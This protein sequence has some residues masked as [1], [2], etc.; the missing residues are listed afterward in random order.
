MTL[1]RILTLLN[2][3]MFL[4][5]GVWGFY[6]PD[7][8][9]AMSDMALPTSVARAEFRSFYGGVCIGLAMVLGV[10]WVRGRMREAL[11]V[12]FWVYGSILLGRAIHWVENG[13]LAAQTWKLAASEA[14]LTLLAWLALRRV[15]T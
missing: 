15:R 12:Q 10:A 4:G 3:A 2:I 13:G 7:T 9:A 14:V 6:Q 8:L 1:A 11:L 5:F